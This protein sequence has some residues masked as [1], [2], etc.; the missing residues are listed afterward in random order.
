MATYQQELTLVCESHRLVRG[1][2]GCAGGAAMA[3]WLVVTATGALVVA[4]TG[5]EGQR[6]NFS[7]LLI[8]KRA[9]TPST[10]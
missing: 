9:I 7:F 8:K 3:T 10:M 5:A 1:M 4:A 6:A 2:V